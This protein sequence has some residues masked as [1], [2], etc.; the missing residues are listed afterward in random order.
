MTS[1]RK[2]AGLAFVSAHA[3]YIYRPSRCFES[4]AWLNTICTQT[5]IE[6][7]ETRCQQHPLSEECSKRP[8]SSPVDV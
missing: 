8:D 4:A 7:E 6:T 3:M 1:N 5:R 2:P